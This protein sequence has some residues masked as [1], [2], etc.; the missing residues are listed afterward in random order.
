[1]LLA[2]LALAAAVLFA[3][4]AAAANVQKRTRLQNV[5]LVGCAPTPAV[6]AS[7]V[8]NGMAEVA[9]VKLDDGHA[10]TRYRRRGGNWVLVIFSSNGVACSIAA[11]PTWAGDPLPGPGL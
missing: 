2:L 7:M 4:A 1:M 5:F 8:A 6:A 9:V 10:I 3:P 11:G